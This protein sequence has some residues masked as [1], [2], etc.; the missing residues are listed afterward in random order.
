MPPQELAT[1]A[2]GLSPSHRV[3]GIDALRGLAVV[4]VVLHHI[5][6]RFQIDD[7]DVAGLLP[8]S[9][10]TA[11]FW[12]GYYSVITFFV[13]SGFL[14]TTLSIRRWISLERI[15]L[16]RFYRLRGARI[17]PCLLLLLTVLSVLQWAGASD[18]VIHPERASLV[19]ALVAALTF[20]VNWLEGHRGYLPANWDVLWSLSV[21]EAFYLLFPLM[22]LI[23]RTE[24]WIMT[25]MVALIVVGPFNRVALEGRDPWS[26]YAYLS[27][28]DGIAFGCVTAWITARV[29]IGLPMLR[30][31]M[32][33]GVAIA[34][35][36]VVFR[37]QISDLGLTKAGLNVT[38]L[39]LGV[40]LVLIGLAH[41]VGNATVS[42]GTAWLRLAGRC[43]YE[44]Y[45]THMF[46]VLGLMHP[47]R[48]LFG[49]WPA[50]SAAYLVTYGIMLVLSILLGYAVERWFSAPLNEA[51]RENWS[52]GGSLTL[53]RVRRG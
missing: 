42:R 44:I 10:G 29:R 28:V 36:I 32:A 17:L 13:I 34:I 40:S 23:L 16:S 18:F 43:S 51:L 53:C 8:G 5:N 24:R 20:H 33:V 31:A 9:V 11:L 7:Y 27:C 50:A 4:L 26:D 37:K 19:R 45:L 2:P 47:F 25:C 14:I 38:A 6:L 39:E 12:S 49:A 22:C 41:G 1:A 46:V 52:T 35:S 48:G 30:A 15:P 21:E 3:R